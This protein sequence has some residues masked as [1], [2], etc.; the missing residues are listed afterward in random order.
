MLE[1]AREQA[2]RGGWYDDEFRGFSRYAL[3][4]FAGAMTTLPSG[5]G[6]RVF[7]TFL[8]LGLDPLGG[9]ELMRVFR[10]HAGQPGHSLSLVT[11][12]ASFYERNA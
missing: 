10:A 7:R 5:G 11:E 4:S 8:L 1:C 12:F 9:A 2:L 3:V 6:E